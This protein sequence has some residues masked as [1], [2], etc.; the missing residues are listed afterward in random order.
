M[1]SKEITIDQQENKKVIFID[2]WIS[3]VDWLKMNVPSSHLF[4]FI[5]RAVAGIAY[6][7]FQRFEE[8]KPVFWIRDAH[9]QS[10][11]SSLNHRKV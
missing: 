2:R 6:V 4:Q 10:S 8:E 1:V 5:R 3:V 9:Q 7:P 11:T